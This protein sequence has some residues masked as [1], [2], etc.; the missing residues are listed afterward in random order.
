M[1]Q[2]T[3][4]YKGDGLRISIQIDEIHTTNNT[5]TIS[6]TASN[7]DEH[8][9]VCSSV[10]IS[11]LS[12]RHLGIWK[13]HR[14]SQD[15]IPTVGSAVLSLLESPFKLA[16]KLVHDSSNDAND[17]SP[18]ASNRFDVLKDISGILKPKT[19]TLLLGPP[20]CGRS[21]LMKLL[22]HRVRA[23][24]TASHVEGDIRFHS[25]SLTAHQLSHIDPG[26]IVD[27]VE[28]IEN[29]AALLT[30]EETLRYSYMCSTVDDPTCH[31]PL[32]VDRAVDHILDALG[33]RSCKDTLVGDDGVTMRGISGGEKRR[34]TLGEMLITP[35]P[36][37]VMD[38][39][40]DGLDAATAVDIIRYLR[41]S[42]QQNNHSYLIAL[43]Q[44]P[45]TIYELFDEVILM[46]GGEVIYHG[47]R[48]QAAP[49]FTSLGFHCPSVA[50]DGSLTNVDALFIK[51][52][53][54]EKEVESAEDEELEEIDFLQELATNTG[55][56]F[57]KPTSAC[58]PTIMAYYNKPITMSHTTYL[59]NMWKQSVQ[60]H[61]M[62]EEIDELCAKV[63]DV[64]DPSIIIDCANTSC[65]IL[66]TITTWWY[67]FTITL[68]KYG[69][70]E[71][72][73]K[74]YY[75][76]RLIPT[77]IVAAFTGSIFQGISVDDV[78]T[79]TGFLYVNAMLIAVGFLSYLPKLYDHRRWH[80]KYSDASFYPTSV[81]TIALTI[82]I[83]PLFMFETIAQ[84][85]LMYWITGL[86]ADGYGS[87]FAFF[88]LATQLMTLCI[89]T[90]FRAIVILCPVPAIGVAFSGVLML[91]F[92]E[93]SGFVQPIQAAPS[94]LT[95]CYYL[96]PGYWTLSAMSINE[97]HTSRYDKLVCVASPSDC[98]AGVEGSMRR[99]GS[100]ALEQYGNP[101]DDENY[102]WFCMGMV[103]VIY[104]G[105]QVVLTMMLNGRRHEATPTLPVREC[106]DTQ[107]AKL[108]E[109][110]MDEI[111]TQGHRAQR[112]HTEM[113]TLP[114]IPIDMTF[115][116]VTYTVQVKNKDKEPPSAASTPDTSK[117]SSKKTKDAALL[118]NV[119]GF[120]QPGT[121]TALMGAT[122]A[123]KTT[124][125][126]VL[127]MRKTQGDC[128]G[129]ICF[130]GKPTDKHEEEFKSIMVSC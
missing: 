77:T 123:G 105:M 66:T 18:S 120:F 15:D 84:G 98:A 88:L 47:T 79:M 41:A 63:H 2:T 82:I 128:T 54:P 21:L 26:K 20:G 39:I 57:Y 65:S 46:S 100:L 40:T 94:Y 55:S 49:Y 35:R 90:Y 101:T 3:Q 17:S 58:S 33:L 29:H 36:I 69:A 10:P 80:E 1:E 125:L 24:T 37:K 95:W 86:S 127:A 9:V 38:S 110:N 74:D 67:L 73:S 113:L 99:L 59:A 45:S 115:E 121:M 52:E 111:E 97:Y 129:E 42:C 7:C 75:L 28:Q 102:K 92:S 96:D 44:A 14:V 117:R 83:F 48:A 60:Y 78:F 30:V 51:N 89:S 31:D 32:K 81:H 70:I 130:N 124:L 53:N 93:F 112:A 119:R 4:E 62:L 27:Y 22:S 118:S 103:F 114:F 91:L 6:S 61:V 108:K 126:D 85:T 16:T 71:K 106:S 23:T 72:R 109:E 5:T 64:S 116:H 68:S 11:T 25:D 76:T 50:V 8:H 122:G 104:M 19:M 43:N 56:R 107:S 13:E 87:A 12:F 34:L